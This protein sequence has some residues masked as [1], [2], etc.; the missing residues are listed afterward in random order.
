MSQDDPEEDA[1]LPVASSAVVG[2][3]RSAGA[4][5]RSVR[6]YVLWGLACGTVCL[7]AAAALASSLPRF[8]AFY[9]ERPIIQAVLA[10]IASVVE[11]IGVG[12]FVSSVA[13]FLYE[14]GAESYRALQ[15]ADRLQGELDNLHKLEARRTERRLAHDVEARLHA[16]EGAARLEI[17]KRIS[18]LVESIA[19]ISAHRTPLS[20]GRL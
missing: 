11:H 3:K 4:A 8:K 18:K 20:E 12:F 7:G 13:V 2:E 1:N 15:L 16:E 10:G 17:A 9:P 14:W 19:R 6:F 5:F